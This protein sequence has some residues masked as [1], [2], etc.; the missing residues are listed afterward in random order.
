MEKVGQ[1]IQK[2]ISKQIKANFILKT[3]LGK[4]DGAN[5][6]TDNGFKIPQ[7]DYLIGRSVKS[8]LKDGDRVLI[9]W[10]GYGAVVVDGVE[11]S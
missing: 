11:R 1:S 3:E 4:L 2:E 7:G 9:V 6:I 5:L 10:A 8:S